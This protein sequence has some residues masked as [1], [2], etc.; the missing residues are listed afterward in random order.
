MY[1]TGKDMNKNYKETSLGGVSGVIQITSVSESKQR[2]EPRIRS[3]KSRRE[4]IV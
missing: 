4:K 1:E 2:A 3:N